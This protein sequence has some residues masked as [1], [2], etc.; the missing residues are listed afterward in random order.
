[1]LKILVCAIMSG[2]CKLGH[3]YLCVYL[4]YRMASDFRSRK[5]SYKTL[6][7]KKLNFWDKSFRYSHQMTSVTSDSKM[8]LTF[9]M[10][11][12][13]AIECLVQLAN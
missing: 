2:F 3:I 6:Y 7:H 12:Q 4:T 9:H 5:I 1:M 13:V 11:E 8:G 10:H